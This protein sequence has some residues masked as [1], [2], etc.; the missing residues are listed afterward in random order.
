MR[1]RQYLHQV[2]VILTLCL[3]LA[4]GIAKA[5]VADE[6]NAAT[7]KPVDIGVYV[8]QIY[9]LSLKDNKFCIDFYV[10]FRWQDKELKPFETFEVVNGR[11]DSKEIIYNDQLDGGIFY[12]VVR[13]NATITKFWDIQKFPLDN[14]VL[15]VEIEDSQNESSKF[16]YVA[17]VKNTNIN[18]L[19]QVPGWGLEK[20]SGYALDH[21][22]K[23]NYG[24]ISL[25][26]D[27][28]S[29]YSRFV[30]AQSIKRP[31]YGYFLKL[32]L[33]VFVSALI[34]MLALLIKPTDLDPRFGLGIGAIFAAVASEYVVASSLPDSNII[35][36]PDKLHILAIL[37]IFLSIFESIISLKL[38]SSGREEASR[39]LDLL[40]F[41][42]MVATYLLGNMLIVFR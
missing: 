13:V 2:C 30:F 36:L 33:S 8:S 7:A 24:D 23:T 31:G 3:V 22:Y 18:P 16:K 42:L 19:V 27:A 34:A 37:Y 6:E 28:E 35:T 1:C 17:D 14:H 39:R 12:A 4:W 26:S 40:M 10:W 38:F 9:D 15:T 41:T 29:V 5:Q 20:T 32:F 11:A 25:P 21:A